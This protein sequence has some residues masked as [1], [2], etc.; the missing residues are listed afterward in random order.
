MQVLAYDHTGNHRI[1]LTVEPGDFVHWKRDGYG[2]YYKCRVIKVRE[3][4]ERL[5]VEP[6]L[7]D[8]STGRPKWITTR[9]ILAVFVE[10]RE[11]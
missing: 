3:A 5:Y 10:W 9:N 6:I 2:G 1:L 7:P 8:G 11:R 4:T